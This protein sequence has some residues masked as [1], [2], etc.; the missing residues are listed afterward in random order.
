M[1]D[2]F[3][4]LGTISEIVRFNFKCRFL[5]KLWDDCYAQLI[6]ELKVKDVIKPYLSHLKYFYMTLNK[7]NAIKDTSRPWNRCSFQFPYK[8]IFILKPVTFLQCVPVVSSV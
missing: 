2:T 7:T 1:R 3:Y 5:H 8:L 6:T 4:M